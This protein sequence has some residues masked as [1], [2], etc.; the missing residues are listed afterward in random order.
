MSS[1]K[2]DFSGI[3]SGGL[4][5]TLSYEDIPADYCLEF[6]A[7]SDDGNDNYESYAP[8][9]DTVDTSG[10]KLEKTEDGNTMLV[11]VASLE[12][13]EDED[14]EA[15]FRGCRDSGEIQISFCIMDCDG[16]RVSPWSYH[17]TLPCDEE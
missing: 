3:H 12:D 14:S 1:I 10:L 17:Y 5:V 7:R 6:N 4:P 2:F 16:N 11:G 15:F 8:D 9:E 13:P